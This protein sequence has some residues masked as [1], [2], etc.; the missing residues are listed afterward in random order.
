MR[1]FFLYAFVS[2]TQLL[3]TLV[4]SGQDTSLRSEPDFA[5]MPEEVLFVSE[6]AEDIHRNLRESE[7]RNYLNYELPIIAFILLCMGS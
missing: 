4:G 3:F 2:F 1:R 5:L 7:V 6:Y